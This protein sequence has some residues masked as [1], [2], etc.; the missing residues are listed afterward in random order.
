MSGSC[1]PDFPTMM[2]CTLQLEARR[3]SFSLER[4]MQKIM[5]LTAASDERREMEQAGCRIPGGQ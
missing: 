4:T 1:C 5:R 3:T 2:D